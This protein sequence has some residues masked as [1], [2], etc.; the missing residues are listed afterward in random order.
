MIF[1]RRPV[2]AIA[3]TA[4]LSTLSIAASPKNSKKA[5]TQTL[6][7]YLVD[8]SCAL[9]KHKS[10]DWAAKH[11]KGCLNMD[12]CIKSGYAILTPD[13]KLYKFDAKGNAEARKLIDATDKK[14]DWKITLK[15]KVDAEHNIVA[16]SA[17]DLQR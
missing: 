8:N 9:E 14:N 11:G 3:L 17:L 10:A 4:I 6:Q 2:T 13:Q 5:A 16:V 15:G 12:E 7:G 1:S